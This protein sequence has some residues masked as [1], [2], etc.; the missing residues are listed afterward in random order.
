MFSKKR[1][2]ILLAG[3]LLVSGGRD[4][5]AQEFQVVV[6][7][8]NP[9]ASMPKGEVAEVFLKRK[10]RWS[11]GVAITPVDQAKNSPLRDAFSR[12]V[13]GKPATAIVSFWQQQIFSGK[14]VPPAER[15]SDSAVIEFVRDNPGAVGY[16]SPGAT[17][18]GGVKRLTVD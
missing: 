1:I 8:A 17:L 16:V 3:L 5:Q 11:N 6:N 14:D 4:A 10:A 12:G 2:I 9:T 13:H 18:G 15:T 7:A